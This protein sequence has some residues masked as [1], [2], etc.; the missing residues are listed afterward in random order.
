MKVL[1]ADEDEGEEACANYRRESRPCRVAEAYLFDFSARTSAVKTVMEA[2]DA[3]HQ[4]E[5][6]GCQYCRVMLLVTFDIKNAYNSVGWKA[7]L[8]TLHNL[9]YI[10]S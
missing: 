8:G 10:P 5:T 7:N 6:H 4:G 1:P 3:V 2:V 9:F